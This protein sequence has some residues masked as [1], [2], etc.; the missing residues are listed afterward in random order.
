[1]A[2]LFSTPLAE[3]RGLLNDPTGAIYQ[4][5]PMITLGN[6][7]YKELQTKLVAYGISTSR[8]VSAVI[9]VAAGTVRLG[10]GA[11]LPT[12]LIAP[13]WLW[14]RPDN[15]TGKFV[16]MDETEWE[17]EETQGTEL[18]YWSWRE[19]EIKFLGATTP[20]EVK[21]R[22]W[23]SLG[24]IS[25]TNS[26]I[27]ILNSEQWLAQRLAAVASL[28]LGSNPTRAAALQADLTS[29]WDDFIAATLKRRQGIPVRRK[30]TRYRTP[31]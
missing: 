27:A 22:Y 18:R 17:P 30:R 20:R 24:S 4:D 15:S 10:D 23:K 14:E 11:G 29:I 28:T 31:R 5:T 3:A 9:D 6:K 8:E 1:M 2:I 26:P 7:V 25:A 21:I 12:D 13:I 16:D 19:E